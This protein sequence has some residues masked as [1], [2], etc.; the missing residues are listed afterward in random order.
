MALTVGSLFSGIGGIDLGLERAGMV[1]K[2]QV[3]NDPFCLRVLSKH[4]PDVPKYRDIREVEPAELERVDMLAGGFPC[5]PV[6]QA[7]KRKG[8]EDERWLW[9]EF[10][11]FIRVLRPRLVLLENVPG[12][13]SRGFDDVLRDLATGGYDAEWDCIPAASFGAP[14]IRYRV[15][16]VAYSQCGGRQEE[17][18]GLREGETRQRRRRSSD[19][20]SQSRKGNLFD[21]DSTGRA[22]QWRCF[23]TPPKHQA[24][25]RSDWWEVEPAVGRVVDGLPDRVDRIRSLGNAV[26]PQVV[27]WIGRRIIQLAN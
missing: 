25:E 22:Q 17:R 1:I 4:W 26:V 24:I 20:S 9:P 14:H 27:E 15:F 2:W 16:I 12:L 18:C 21:S 19:S 13:L 6:S 10:F 23:T 8:K 3:E 11:R 7:G 5:Q